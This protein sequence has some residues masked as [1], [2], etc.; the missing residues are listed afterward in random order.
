MRC[1]RCGADS[2][3]SGPCSDC[4]SFQ[5]HGAT[6]AVTGY[7]DE[8][9]TRAGTRAA[10][11]D[12][13]DTSDTDALTA[14]DDITAGWPGNASRPQPARPAPPSKNGGRAPA[15]HDAAADGG[16]LVAGQPFGSRYHIIR[17]LGV[18]GMGAVYHAWDADLGVAVAIKVIRPEIMADVQ[19]AADVERRFKRELLLARQ[20]TH[21]NVVRIHDLGE[22]GGIKYITMSFVNGIDLATLLKREGKLKVEMVMRLA[23]SIVSG[24]VAAH[25]A[26][27]VHRDLKPANLMLGADGDAMIMDFGIARSSSVA[28]TAAA[29]AAA[30]PAHLR[31]AATGAVTG[32]TDN[33]IVGTVDYMAPEQAKG[34]QADQRA[35]IY[36]FGLILYDLLAG[37]SRRAPGERPIAELKARMLKAPPPA[38]S[39]NPGIPEALDALISRC[40]DPSPDKRYQTTT[41]LEADLNR[42]D[43]AGEPVPVKRVVGV[44]L[45]AAVITLAIALIGGSWYYA[46]TLIPA[47]VHDPVSV[48]IADLKNST[49]DP[50]FDRTLEPMMKRALEGA[51]FVS[52]Y[53]R[54]AIVR[55]LGVRPPETLD[56]TAARELAVKQGLGVVLSGTLDRLGT[57]YRVSVKAT[58]TV[59]GAVLADRKARAA[60]RE[61]VLGVANRLVADVRRALGDEVSESAQIFAMTNLSATSLDVVRLYAAAQEAASN[62][63][64]EEARQNAL[65]AV[66][67]DPKFGIGYQLLSVAS[68]NV[69]NLQDA[70]K[71]INEALRYLDTMTERERY[72]TRGFYYR[73]AGDW[74][75]CVKEYGDLVARYAADPV[76]HNQ[77]ALCLTKLRDMG[78][79]VAEMQKVVAMLPNRVVFRD[80]LA[81]YAN[82]AG[83]FETAEK[84]ARTIQEPDVYAILAIAL[85]QTGQGLLTEAADTYRKLAAINAQG[86]SFAASGL[87]DLA[88]Y[89]GRYSDAARILEQGA[90]A[91]LAANNPD[92]AAM[93]LVALANAQLLRGQRGPALAA[94]EKALQNSRAVPIRFLSARIFV[95]AGSADKSSALAA[96]LAAELPVEPQAYAKILGGEAAL[97][98]GDARQAI[99]LLLEANGMLDTWIGAFELGRAYLEAG[100]LPQA[101]SQ[102]DRAIKRRGEA[103][104]LFLDEEPTFGYFPPAYYYQGR[105]R[106]G[107][108]NAG[109]AD[110]YRQ[111]L[112]V[113][114]H[115]TEDRLLPEIRRRAGS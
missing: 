81:L 96:S 111:Y 39:I 29:V 52:A 71:Y 60:T 112:K 4:Q 54:N 30:L 97:A 89:E 9:P 58:Q 106:E 41:E 50:A 64:F 78:G 56:E 82:Y 10:P 75:Q 100:A 15:A 33:G 48:V 74:Q 25:A 77:R 5:A 94:A 53:D 38:R 2:S 104:S 95:Q 59:T 17:I 110:S 13:A 42:L 61:A 36:S 20:V 86:A 27:V 47:A 7:L 6:G 102:F 88:V 115:S 32:V 21:K 63:K 34:L 90:N 14:D 83:D 3:V 93:K 85:A 98:S 37:R 55:T 92:K 11:D 101:D 87:G 35:D 31:L 1:P 65:K 99:K 19:T 49:G 67:L 80:N 12:P 8:Y 84:E 70:E 22:I 28:E 46:R 51:S 114:G 79:A 108:K 76:G 72:T 103:L 26:G 40:L 107:M 18:G 68:R 62:N 44:K 113:R 109:F 57:G 69:G 45:L 91:D 16:P 23:R 24:L 43:D 66:E 73:V 105:V